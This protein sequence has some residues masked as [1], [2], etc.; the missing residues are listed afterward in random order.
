MCSPQALRIDA[1]FR[2]TLAG[3]LDMS[4][5]W[6]TDTPGKSGLAIAPPSMTGEGAPSDLSV[7]TGGGAGATDAFP[8][9]R[10]L[11]VAAAGG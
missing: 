8:R 6:L 11:A 5:A 9:F 10:R 7:A 1:L 3:L 2:R 4:S